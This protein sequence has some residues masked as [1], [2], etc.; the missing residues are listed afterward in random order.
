MNHIEKCTIVA[1]IVLFIIVSMMSIEAT[2]AETTSFTVQYPGD[3]TNPTYSIVYTINETSADEDPTVSIS[4]INVVDEKT[5]INPGKTAH[6][7]GIDYTITGI[8]DDAFSSEEVKKNVRRVDVPTTVTELSGP[9]FENMTG[10]EYLS[11]L[12]KT[13]INGQGL[14]RNCNSLTTI[15]MSAMVN[16]TLD[17]S[18]EGC[19]SLATFDKPAK[20]VFGNNAFKD[21]TSLTTVIASGCTSILS[22]AFSGCSD[23]ST[24]TVAKCTSITSNAFNGCASLS[25]VKVAQDCNIATNSF[26]DCD[27]LELVTIG[28]VNYKVEN[29][30]VTTP[31]GPENAVF[32]IGE[33]Y[34][35]SVADMMSA[36][37]FGDEVIML[38]D[39]ETGGISFTET[40]TF[41][42][43]GNNLTI[44]APDN[45]GM[46]FIEGGTIEN[47]SINATSTADEMFRAIVLGIGYG[48]TVDDVKLTIENAPNHEDPSKDYNNVGFQVYGKSSLTL[49][50]D[51]VIDTSN[52]DTS[53]NSVSVIVIGDERT[54]PSYV[55]VKDNTRIEVGQFGISGDGGSG[56]G[57]TVI[58]IADDTVVSASN[59]WGVYHPQSGILNINGNSTISGL[60]GIEI[61]S[62]TLNMTGGTVYSTA[63]N[64]VSTPNGGGPTSTGAAIA[65]SQHTT[66]LDISVNISGGS[67]SGPSA[68]YEKDLM[69][70]DSSNVIISVS[71]GKFEGSV[72]SDNVGGFITGGSFDSDVSEYVPEGYD[73][74][75]KDGSFQISE[76]TDLPPF[77][78]DDEDY[79][80]IP[81]VVYDDSDDDDTVTIVACAAAAVVAAILAVF[82]IVERKR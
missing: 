62:G 69:D 19:K 13:T 5:R 37:R 20:V 27:S 33:N 11:I 46:L 36:V 73:C 30:S 44:N 31:I 3:D 29:G 61:R 6:Y 35:N 24:V 18:F 58:E 21:C 55:R 80:P 41:N 56:H 79:V 25:Y 47:G 59:G 28:S 1:S 66:N 42:L 40:V 63:D 12:G 39:V 52:I 81:P 51:T 34:Y 54:D 15:N 22:N 78:N 50:G 14:A 77:W 68:L 43:N 45:T 10:L 16:G 65:I 60:T 74:S 72:T 17:S 67:L 23:L 76:K 38:K 48:L 9:I 49:K 70:E 26:H 57:N 82:L 32:Q 53:Y 71:S 8:D 75:N 4:E 2:D 7:N 64:L